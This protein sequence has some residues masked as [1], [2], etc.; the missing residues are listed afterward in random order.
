MTGDAMLLHHHY[1]LR[2]SYYKHSEGRIMITIMLGVQLII[3]CNYTIRAQEFSSLPFHYHPTHSWRELFTENFT[4]VF[5]HLLTH[6]HTSL[7]LPSIV[8]PFNPLLTFILFSL[9]CTFL[10]EW[11]LVLYTFQRVMLLKAPS[12]IS[13][14]SH[15][16]VWRPMGAKIETDVD[17]PNVW[18]LAPSRA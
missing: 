7:P 13:I 4:C 10:S 14:K 1:H 11:T 6:W 16:G 3:H 8:S 12:Y 17:K 18:W 15:S 2:F 9:L 5:I